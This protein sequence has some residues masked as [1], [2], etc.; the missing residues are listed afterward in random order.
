MDQYVLIYWEQNKPK[1]KIT[2]KKPL[3]FG[4]TIDI[5]PFFGRNSPINDVL[6]R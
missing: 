4:E 2:V 5:C 6:L 3:N 1:L